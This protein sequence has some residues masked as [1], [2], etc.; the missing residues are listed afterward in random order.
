MWEAL[1]VCMYNISYRLICVGLYTANWQHLKLYCN[2]PPRKQ[3]IPSAI[4]KFV[5]CTQIVQILITVTNARILVDDN[6]NIIWL[7]I[8]LHRNSKGSFS[9]T[10]SQLEGNRC[11]YYTQTEN[12][13]SC[14]HKTYQIQGWSQ[15][16]LILSTVHRTCPKCENLSVWVC[17]CVIVG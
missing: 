16:S 3:C 10:N 4:Y 5:L 11:P 14:I 12:I 2:S 9:T 1:Y 17:V 8:A 15:P 13:I 6:H 7:N